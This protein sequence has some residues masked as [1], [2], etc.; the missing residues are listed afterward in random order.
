MRGPAAKGITIEDVHI[1]PEEPLPYDIITIDASGWVGYTGPQVDYT[2]FLMIDESLQLDM[3]FLV[4]DLPA[5]TPWSY[6]EDIPSLDAG[7][8]TLTVRAFEP[9]YGEPGN[10]YITSFTVVSE[11]ATIAL[12]AIGALLLTK[13]Y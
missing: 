2:E 7:S 8:Y 1:T 5:V 12:L 11:P 13:R 10:T 9:P 3:F 4:G 6:S